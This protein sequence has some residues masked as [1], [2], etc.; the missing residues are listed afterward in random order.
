[1]ILPSTN[2]D[3]N[4]LLPSEGKESVRKDFQGE[5]VL[6]CPRFVA[7]L[8]VCLQ[9]QKE[10]TTLPTCSYIL[11]IQLSKYFP[12]LKPGGEAYTLLLP[13]PIIGTNNVLCFALA[14][15]INVKRLARTAIFSLLQIF[16][17]HKR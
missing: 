17:I 2:L 1:M 11:W 13:R 16:K 3:I 4:N 10:N 12:Q 9:Q 14:I 5:N 15:I 8:K 7:N 6:V